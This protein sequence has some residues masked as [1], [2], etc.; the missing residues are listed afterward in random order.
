MTDL[1]QKAPKEDREDPLAQL[2]KMSTTAGLGTTDYVAVNGLS[3]VV[4][5][6]G[7]ASALSLLDVTFLVSLPPLTIV[8]AIIAL[9][10]IGN[11]NGTQTGKGL[12]ILGLVLALVF[13]AAVGGRELVAIGGNRADQRAIDDLIGQLDRNISE[14]K[15]DQAYALFNGKFTSRVKEQ[16]FTDAWRPVVVNNHRPN[17]H[18]NGRI[19]FETTSEGDKAAVA[20]T[21]IEFMPNTPEQRIEMIFRKMPDGTWK[22]ENIPQLFPAEKPPGARGPR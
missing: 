21:I 18:S 6:L 15:F 3:V 10:Q 8:L 5:I 1:Q 9:R 17:I 12:A 16:A 13:A 14:S 20:M 19:F 7:A 2:H 4:L 11:S 22:I